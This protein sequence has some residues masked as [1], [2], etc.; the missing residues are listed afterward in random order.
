MD[1]GQEPLGPF[2]EMGT[3]RQELKK[4]VFVRPLL[5]VV[6]YFFIQVACWE[7][8]AGYVTDW[9]EQKLD[10]ERLQAV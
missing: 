10:L 3:V 6:V 5:V 8:K 4:K 9:D 1:D 7:Q 2:P